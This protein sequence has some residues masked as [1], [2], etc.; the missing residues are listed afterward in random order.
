M[1]L[2]SKQS[3]HAR[4]LVGGNACL[5]IRKHDHFTPAREMRRDFRGVS[6]ARSWNPLLIL[7]AI[8]WVFIA[9]IAKFS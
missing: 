8:L 7:R 6:H 3:T 2:S 9:K 5:S 1:S 4:P